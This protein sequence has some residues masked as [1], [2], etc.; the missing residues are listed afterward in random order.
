MKGIGWIDVCLRPHVCLRPSMVGRVSDAGLTGQI[1]FTTARG[2]P[3][4]I[5]SRS[6]NLLHHVLFNVLPKLKRYCTTPPGRRGH[7]PRES[8]A[9]CYI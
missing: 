7:S 4:S 1:E 3:S 8:R 5:V 6:L 2:R 9:A